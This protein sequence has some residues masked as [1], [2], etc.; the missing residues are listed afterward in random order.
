M[1]VLEGSRMSV[2]R[3]WAACVALILVGFLIATTPSPGVGQT[4]K[5][6]HTG[7]RVLYMAPIYLA[8]EKGFFKEEASTSTR[9][10]QRHSRQR[11]IGG[12]AHFS[13]TDPPGAQVKDQVSR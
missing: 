3:W 1:R 6:K 9:D 4:M 11:L 12:Q 13:D 7:F 2:H 5:L 10:R 8:I